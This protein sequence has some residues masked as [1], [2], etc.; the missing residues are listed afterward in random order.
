MLDASYEV[1]ELP[2]RRIA[3]ARSHKW[4]V[5]ARLGLQAQRSATDY[6]QK[7]EKTSPAPLT[8]RCFAFFERPLADWSTCIHEHECCARFFVRVILSLLHSPGI[9]RWKEDVL[10]RIGGSQSRGTDASRGAPTQRGKVG[11]CARCAPVTHIVAANVCATG[12]DDWPKCQGVHLWRRPGTR[13]PPY[14]AAR[15][16]ENRNGQ[17]SPDWDWATSAFG[18]PVPAPLTDLPTLAPPLRAHAPFRPPPFVF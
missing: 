10:F 15:F 5:A 13:A 4:H 8:P 2:G 11:F 3:V 9:A 16:Y 6:P 7:A 1:W 12:T 17:I 18:N 14:L